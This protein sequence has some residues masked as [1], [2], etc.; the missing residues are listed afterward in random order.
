MNG[1][2]K[3][4]SFRGL[5]KGIEGKIV[6]TTQPVNQASRLINP[7]TEAGAK[8]Y[9]LPMIKIVY[10]QPDDKLKRIINSLENFNLLV[11]TSRNG[12]IGFFQLLKSITGNHQIPENLKIAVIGEST[13]KEIRKYNH[14][15]H[16]INTG[17]TS[18]EFSE[19][20]KSKVLEVNDKILLALGKLAPNKLQDDL[21]KIVFTE[22]INVYKTIKPEGFNHEILNIAKKQKVDLTV[23]TSPSAFKNFIQITEFS[24]EEYKTAI[25]CIGK[26]TGSYIKSEGYDVGLI[27]NNPKIELFALEI[28]SYL[29]K[30]N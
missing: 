9:N 3:T 2:E 29:N 16:F 21:K 28:I 15:V 11:F 14:S 25:A 24:S 30:S 5:M 7:L 18:D 20:L 22:R 27:A 17:I 26:T 1:Y 23:F 4:N 19:Y 10:T 12:V 13:A 6:I 8:V